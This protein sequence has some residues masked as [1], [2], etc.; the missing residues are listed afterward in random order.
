MSNL[1]NIHGDIPQTRA[2][3]RGTEACHCTE[4][5]HVL[6]TLPVCLWVSSVQNCSCLP[7]SPTLWSNLCLTQNESLIARRRPNTSAKTLSYPYPQFHPSLPRQCI[8]QPKWSYKAV[9]LPW[10]ECLSQKQGITLLLSASWMLWLIVFLTL[11]HL[12]WFISFWHF[13]SW[14]IQT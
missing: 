2:K 8:H 14:P 12:I 11:M 4:I 5:I 13:E 6:I 9:V 10:L 7:S 1:G 3:S